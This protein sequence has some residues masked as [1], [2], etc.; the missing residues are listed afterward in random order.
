[1]STRRSRLPRS[2]SA[3]QSPEREH[4]SFTDVPM[5]GPSDKETSHHATGALPSD[6]LQ[7][8]SG[9]S[10]R[11]LDDMLSEQSRRDAIEPVVETAEPVIDAVE[12]VFETVEPV[13][14]VI[15]P[16][17]ELVEPIVEA[18]SSAGIIMETQSSVAQIQHTT[19]ATEM[20]TAA[21]S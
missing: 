20:T 2:R 14:E 9:S 11:L 5:E 16:V 6:P 13:I 4:L 15:E 21:A 8:L 1:M 10:D 18:G 17:P 3:T 12:P 19:L 7:D